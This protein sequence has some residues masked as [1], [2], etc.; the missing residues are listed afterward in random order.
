MQS[1]YDSYCQHSATIFKH[2]ADLIDTV[3]TR[4]NQEYEAYVQ[5]IYDS[6]CQHSATIFKHEADLIDTVYTRDT[7]VNM[8]TLMLATKSTPHNLMIYK[9]PFK[10]KSSQFPGSNKARDKCNHKPL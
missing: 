8:L 2:E 7:Q 10:Q 9:H 1:I 6:Y 3:Y 5:S 4:D